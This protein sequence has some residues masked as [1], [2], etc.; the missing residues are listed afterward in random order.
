MEGVGHCLHGWLDQADAERDMSV[1]GQCKG[2]GDRHGQ[3]GQRVGQRF[4]GRDRHG[5][6]SSSPLNMEI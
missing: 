1:T 6:I 3:V 4:Q 2:H 5:K